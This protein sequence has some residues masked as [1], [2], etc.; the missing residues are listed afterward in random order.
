VVGRD[1]V[2]DGVDGESVSAGGGVLVDVGS[3]CGGRECCGWQRC[4]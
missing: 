3:V 4:H 2:V 1:G